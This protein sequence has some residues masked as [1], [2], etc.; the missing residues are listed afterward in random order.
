MTIRAM[1]LS[2]AYAILRSEADAGHV[3]EAA[4][5]LFF[6]RELWRGVIEPRDEV[7]A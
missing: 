4:V 2:R 1:S 7:S 6:E 3:E 5:E